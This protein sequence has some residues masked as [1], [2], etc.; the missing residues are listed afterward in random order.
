[1]VG[2]P[3]GWASRFPARNGEASCGAAPGSRSRPAA[4]QSRSAGRCLSP[5]RPFG[6]PATTLRR[7]CDGPPGYCADAPGVPSR[8]SLRRAPQGRGPAQRGAVLRASGDRRR[9]GRPT[10]ASP[11]RGR[12]LPPAPVG[13]VRVTRG[14]T[15][16]PGGMAFGSLARSQASRQGGGGLPP[17]LVGRLRRPSAQLGRAEGRAL[18]GSGSAARCG[19]GWLRRG[20]GGAAP[21]AAGMAR[22]G[23][24]R[25]WPWRR[26]RPGCRLPPGCFGA[27]IAGAG[28]GLTPHRAAYRAGRCG[29]SRAQCSGGLAAKRAF[30]SGLASVWCLSRHS[31]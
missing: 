16:T 18:G 17:A 21:R 22:P 4:R 2:P 5:S 8:H 10:S 31:S 27:G 28:P 15:G 24:R 12:A 11:H 23:V 6:D 26:G 7:A 14:V 19:E 9:G 13:R 25:W 30:A 3:R 20:G 29:R 1:M